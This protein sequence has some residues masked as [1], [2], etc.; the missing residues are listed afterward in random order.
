MGIAIRSVTGS[1]SRERLKTEK[2]FEFAA[3]LLN[4]GLLANASQEFRANA[5]WIPEFVPNPG[6]PPV[7]VWRLCRPEQLQ[8]TRAFP[9]F[10]HRAFN[11][12]QTEMSTAV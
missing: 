3:G 10:P 4:Q 2:Q 9:I 5:L 6:H 7:D 1:T 8:N 11:C 12:R